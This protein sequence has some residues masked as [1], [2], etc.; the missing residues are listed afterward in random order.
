[1]LSVVLNIISLKQELLA[2][3]NLQINIIKTVTNSITPEKIILKNTSLFIFP[4][5][6]VLGGGGITIEQRQNSSCFCNFFIFPIA[7]F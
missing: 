4:H 7:A 5:A 1:M 6:N 2:V 3:L